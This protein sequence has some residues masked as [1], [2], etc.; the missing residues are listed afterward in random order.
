MMTA[1]N[2]T[3]A[4]PLDDLGTQ[5]AIG[6]NLRDLRKEALDQACRTF[7]EVGMIKPDKPDADSIVEAAGKFEAYLRRGV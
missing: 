7:G 1:E 3:K 4:S 2:D 5:G 6:D